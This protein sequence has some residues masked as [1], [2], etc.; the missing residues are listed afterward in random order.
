MNLYEIR[1]ILRG[2]IMTRRLRLPAGPASLM[3]ACH[4]CLPGLG[5]VL[6]AVYPGG[7]LA[8]HGQSDI[9]NRDFRRAVHKFDHTW[10]SGR[11]KEVGLATCAGSKLGSRYSGSGHEPAEIPT[12]TGNQTGTDNLS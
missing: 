1:N 3:S 11:Q 6:S 8:C 4:I 9:Y 10:S 12:G 7:C 5:T 2:C